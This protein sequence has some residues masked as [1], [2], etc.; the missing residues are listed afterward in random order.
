MIFWTAVTIMVVVAIGTEFI[1][2]LVKIGTKFSEN[3][4]RIEH[5]YPTLDGAVPA[6]ETQPPESFS[7]SERL[8]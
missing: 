8:Q 3:I 5:G 1:I 6:N 2:R 7:P 4:K